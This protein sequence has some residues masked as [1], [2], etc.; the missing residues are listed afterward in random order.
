MLVRSMV[1]TELQ[2]VPKCF[3]APECPRVLWVTECPKCSGVFQSVPK[4]IRMFQCSRVFIRITFGISMYWLF[5]AGSVSRLCISK[6]QYQHTV[7]SIDFRLDE[8]R[9]IGIH[10]VCSP[11]PGSV[12]GFFN[13][14]LDTVSPKKKK[15][16]SHQFGYFSIPKFWNILK[17]RGR[18]L[19][20]K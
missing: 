10:L 5:K 9:S 6:T 8:S 20:K 7:T 15:R 12:F 1:Q 17:K 13:I 11:M 16:I 14:N 2:S 19:G 4:C 3:S 18:Q